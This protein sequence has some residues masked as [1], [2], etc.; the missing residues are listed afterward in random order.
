M[1]VLKIEGLTKQF[2]GLTAV[3]DVTFSIPRERFTDLLGRTV[4]GKQRFTI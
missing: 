2:G 3:S 1:D 4:Q